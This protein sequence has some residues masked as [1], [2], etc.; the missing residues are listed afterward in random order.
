MVLEYLPTFARTKSPSF[1]GKYTIHGGYGMIYYD[2]DGDTKHTHLYYSYSISMQKSGFSLKSPNRKAASSLLPK[3]SKY[4]GG[5]RQ[6]FPETNS[7]MMA[8]E[9]RNNPTSIVWR[10]VSNWHGNVQFLQTKYITWFCCDSSWPSL[11]HGV[12]LF[13]W[14]V[15]S[16]PLKNESVGMIMTNCWGK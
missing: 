13:F 8:D 4:G 6:V 2:Y 15:V 9:S 3:S 5:V 7:G 12:K 1:V 14:L 10:N 16:T 11:W